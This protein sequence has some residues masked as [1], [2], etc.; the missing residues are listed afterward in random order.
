MYCTYVPSEDP[1]H[2]LY[3]TT[4]CSTTVYVIETS[5][6]VGGIRVTAGVQP[7]D[8]CLAYTDEQPDIYRTT[9]DVKT[10]GV[11]IM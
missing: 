1:T 2:P 9:P 7:T 4:Y 10:F 5:A 11:S 8:V 3:I 6:P